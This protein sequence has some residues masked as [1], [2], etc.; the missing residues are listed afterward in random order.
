MIRFF[1]PL[2]KFLF[3][4]TFLLSEK[5]LFAGIVLI[6]LLRFFGFLLFPSALISYLLHVLLLALS[7]SSESFWLFCPLV[8]IFLLRDLI[9]LWI[10][11]LPDSVW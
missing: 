10:L 5:L 7:A 6:I 3:L 2:Y 11:I 4:L 1:I 8:F 9:I